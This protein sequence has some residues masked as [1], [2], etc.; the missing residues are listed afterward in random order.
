MKSCD[1][2]Q[3]EDSNS[4]I[5]QQIYDQLWTTFGPQHWWPGDTA[6]EVVIGAILTQNT[7]WRNVE[8]ALANLK[9]HAVLNPQAL[10]RMP[11]ARLAELIRPAGYYNVKATR[12]R[13]FLQFFFEN[14]QGQFETMEEVP[15]PRLRSEILAVNGIGPE[16][17][18]SILLYALNRKKFVVDAYTKRILFRHGIVDDSATYEEMQR[19]FEESLPS[20]RQLFNEYHALIVRTG[21]DYCRPSPR[22]D[23]C[24]LKEIAYNLDNRCGLCH[25][26]M[27][28]KAKRTLDP[29]GDPVVC[30]HCQ[31]RELGS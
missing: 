20:D 13:N 15:T 28:A 2:K 17:A 29:D 31:E 4:H 7:N 8:R 21:K 22:C 24:P 12:I 11:S 10:R 14:Y 18:D 9:D 27:D 23:Q 25:R 30:D 5:L 19:L 3:S 16:T 1:P 6:F 26:V